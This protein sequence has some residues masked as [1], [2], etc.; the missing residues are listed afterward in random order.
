MAGSPWVFLPLPTCF[1]ELYVNQNKAFSYLYYRTQGL[2]GVTPCLQIYTQFD[3]NTCQPMV[4]NCDLPLSGGILERTFLA[5]I[6]P[7]HVPFLCPSLKCS[8]FLCCPPSTWVQP[9]LLNGSKVGLYPP[10]FPQTLTLTCGSDL[11]SPPL[12]T[13]HCWSAP[14]WS[15]YCFCWVGT[16]SL[17]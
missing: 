16:V 8:P 6:S 14:S 3:S 13:S 1:S 11:L 15:S 5:L 9:T 7:S 17:K 10:H 2:A 12:S 4:G